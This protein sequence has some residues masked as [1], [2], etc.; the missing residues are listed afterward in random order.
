M[1][2]TLPA[3]IE[4]GIE[5]STARRFQHPLNAALFTWN[6]KHPLEQAALL[7]QAC[8]ESLNFT[9]MEENFNWRNPA[10]LD[11]F[12]SNVKGT[13]D[14]EALIALG[15]K[16]IANRIYGG[17]KDLGNGDELSGD[18]WRFRGRGP[19]QLTGRDNYTRCGAAN[20]KPF[21]LIPELV[22]LPTEGCLAMAWY[23]VT[24]GCGGPA[25][26][27]DIDAVTALINPAMAG[28]DDRRAR[29]EDCYNALEVYAG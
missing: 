14:A 28:A 16:A 23:W 18:G 17:R 24:T 29:F 25:L 22:A 5:P 8:H 21:H 12:F 26:A 20:G 11:R 3:L 2:I 15:P 7:A 1:I 6:I 4:C 19:F 9:R 13:A 27:R 10:R